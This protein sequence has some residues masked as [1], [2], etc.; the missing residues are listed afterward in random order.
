MWHSKHIFIHDFGLIERFLCDHLRELTEQIPPDEWFFIRYWQGGPH[1]RLRYRFAEEE[2]KAAFDRL[3][4]NTLKTF[5]QSHGG[6]DFRPVDYDPRIVRLEGVDDLGIHPNFSIRDIPYV[7]ELDR[8]GGEAAMPHSEALFFRSSVTAASIIGSVEWPKRYVAAFDLMQYS[9]EIAAA[10]GMAESEEAFFSDY[11]RVWDAFETDERQEAVREALARR[12]DR[13]RERAEIPAVYRSY[14][15]ELQRLMK[16][17]LDHQNTFPP[18]TVHYLM[19][20]H[21]HMMNNRLGL[22]PENERFLSGI[23][24]GR[25]AAV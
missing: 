24:L 22:S 4:E 7:P 10:L 6:H 14:L 21:I 2:R 9:F 16:Q 12:M 3:L 5:E 17:I 25:R 19:V 13:N 23:F 11:R 20:S 15:D 18:G 8:Y 1:I